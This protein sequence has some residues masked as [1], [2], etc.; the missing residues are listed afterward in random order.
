ML[1]NHILPN[2]ATKLQDYPKDIPLVML[3]I[4]RFKAKT[5]TNETGQKAYTR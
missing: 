3:N 5:S 4:L 2:N 1:S